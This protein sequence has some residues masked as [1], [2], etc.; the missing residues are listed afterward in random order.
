VE[1]S[2]T[3]SSSDELAKQVRRPAKA[4]AVVGL[5][6]RLLVLALLGLF[7]IEPPSNTTHDK[8]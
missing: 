7:L 6:A 5:I 4:F 1:S 8:A 2:K 3:N